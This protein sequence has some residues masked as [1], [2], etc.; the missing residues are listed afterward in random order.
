MADPK[1]DTA[2]AHRHFAVSC[3]NEAWAVIDAPDRSAEDE[4]RMLVL[5]YASLHH[6]MQRPDATDRNRSIGCW[7]ISRVHAILGEAAPA[8]RWGLAALE[9]ARDAGAFYVGYAHEAIAR[10]AA[11]AGDADL[12]R[13][14]LARARAALDAIEDADD[15]APLARDLDAIQRTLSA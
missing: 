5:A 14:H 13:E 12:A 3:F 1:F 9:H 15:R 8:L 7:Q 6:W 2:A 11:C 4:L 10:A